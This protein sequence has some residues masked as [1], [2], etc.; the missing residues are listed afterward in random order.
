MQYSVWGVFY[1]G[2]YRILRQSVCHSY[3]GALYE[4]IYR[5]FR[6]SLFHSVFRKNIFSNLLVL[7]RQSWFHSYSVKVYPGHYVVF[8]TNPSF[9]RYVKVCDIDWGGTSTF[10]TMFEALCQGLLKS[11]ILTAAGV[12]VSVLIPPPTPFISILFILSLIFEHM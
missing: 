3:L 5:V 12:V 2:I 7:F 1:E 11:C 6:R 10:M 8:H 4:S 9:D